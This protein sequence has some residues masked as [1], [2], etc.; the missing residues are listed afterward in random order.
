MASIKLLKV[1]LLAVS[2]FFSAA[3][4]TETLTSYSSL[5]NS[6]KKFISAAE[7]SSKDWSNPEELSRVWQ[8]SLVR[9]PSDNRNYIKSSIKNIESETIQ[10]NKKYPTVIYLHG[11]SGIWTGT[12]WR[13]NYLAENGFA[14]I[15][16]P[17][18]AR[19]K[20]PRS[21]DVNVHQG[22]YYRDIIKIRQNDAGNAIENAKKLPWV[23]ENNIFL[24]GL[25]EGG[26]TTATFHSAN[27]DQSVNAR[28][29]EGWTCHAGWEE[30]KG[31]NA[32]KTEPV[33]TLLGSKDPWFQ[34]SYTNG[35]CTKFINQENG[36]K[37][38]VYT[39]GDL[40]YQHELLENDEVQK[41]L[42]EFLQ[43]HI[44]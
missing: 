1:L 31:I 20:Y 35:E 41:L 36:S 42:L 33:L 16:P 39:E 2:V 10:K 26:I 11:C 21:C 32:P 23:D 37:S 15:A 27:K 18:F 8:A 6:G 24:M 44:H 4:C 13:I 14:V 40:S 19:E 30:Y 29:V 25:S 38:I 34:N 7:M 17:S 5:G 3:A 22:G 43:Q 28:I 12:L 9:I